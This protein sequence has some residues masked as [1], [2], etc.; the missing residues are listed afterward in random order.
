MFLYNLTL[1]V[2]SGIQVSCKHMK[3]SARMPSCAQLEGS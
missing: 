3:P 2:A 1:Q